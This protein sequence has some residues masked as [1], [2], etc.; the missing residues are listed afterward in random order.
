M[1]L[2]IDGKNNTVNVH[3]P[4]IYDFVVGI[5]S[6]D[7]LKLCTKI[8]IHS[9]QQIHVHEAL[10]GCLIKNIYSRLIQDSIEGTLF[11]NVINYL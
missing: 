6:L 10:K 1:I 7:L 5:N 4:T 8:P 11:S 2:N 3:C 9:K